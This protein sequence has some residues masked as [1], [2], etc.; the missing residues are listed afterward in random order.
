MVHPGWSSKITFVRKRY[1]AVTELI[2][3][4][5]FIYGPLSE[6]YATKQIF[7]KH[8]FLVTKMFPL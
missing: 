2:F 6:P 3:K 5:L 1:H 7:V 8:G 4:V